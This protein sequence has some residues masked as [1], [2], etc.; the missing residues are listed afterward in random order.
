ML[1][2]TVPQLCAVQLCKILRCTVQRD[3]RRPFAN[4]K[5]GGGLA[6]GLLQSGKR[7][8]VRVRVY[9]DVSILCNVTL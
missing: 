7:E 5:K 4:L 2:I 8:G 1:C 9:Y 6:V 3:C